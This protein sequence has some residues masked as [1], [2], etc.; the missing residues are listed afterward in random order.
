MVL[1]QSTVIKPLPSRALLSFNTQN[2]DCLFPGFMP[3]DFAVM[4]GLPHVLT[5]SLLLAVRACLPC[6]PGGLE[7]SVVFVDG[8]NTF[9]LYRVSRLARLHH[10]RPMNVLKQIF[11]SRAFTMHQ[12]TSL[13]LYDLEEVVDKYDAKLVIISDFQRL[14]LDRDIKPDE[15]RQ[16]FSQICAYVSDFAEKKGRIVLATCL[17]HPYS[18]HHAFLHA[19][20][21]ARSSVTISVTNK[22]TYPF[23][24]QFA[25]EKHSL[26]KLGRVD[27][28]C[29]NLTL[30]NFVKG[31][32]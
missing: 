29:E 8:G 31:E 3:G 13:I 12:M 30:D 20:A 2:I 6:Q 15:S 25:L 10:L 4:Y 9:R 18:R 32:V 28:P 23:G 11:I 19:V 5:L 21:C 1:A 27:F 17:P 16:V 7:S 26:F 22:R 24:K 14:Y